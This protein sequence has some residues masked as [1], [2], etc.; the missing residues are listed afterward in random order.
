MAQVV[1]EKV[2]VTGMVWLGGFFGK[3]GGRDHHGHALGPCRRGG[4]TAPGAQPP[5]SPAPG[6][7]SLDSPF[8]HAPLVLQDFGAREVGVDG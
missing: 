1:E 2:E 3:P 4:H 6:E 7:F 8:C 5:P